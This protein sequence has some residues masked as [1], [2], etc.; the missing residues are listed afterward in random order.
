MSRY[1][2]FSELAWPSNAD[3][4]E[5]ALQW[6]QGLT[7]QALDWT[8]RAFDALSSKRL[9]HIDPAR[10]L[11]QLERDLVRHH[12][13]E[14]QTIFSTETDGFP[15]FVPHHEWPEMETR[16]SRSA[17]PPAYDLA[18]VSR[19][20][21]RWAWPI[22][23]KVIPS[24]RALAEYLKDVNEKFVTGIASPLIG[25]GAMM[26]Y[27]LTGSSADVFG[28]LAQQL[29]Q[30]LNQPPDFVD[31]AHK[32]STHPR[33]T[34]PVLSLHHMIMKCGSESRSNA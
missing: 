31:R 20:N 27:L 22:E 6:A 23:A 12:F 19:T 10:P 1:P 14:I 32:T 16:T 26:G 4:R 15:S 17:K 28:K 34:A 7:V 3:D 25:A 24:P 2:T 21:E 5:M 8:W 9:T 18:F 33:S 13:V 30:E 11:E 29:G